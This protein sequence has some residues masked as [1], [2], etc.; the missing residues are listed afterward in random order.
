[1]QSSVKNVYGSILAFLSV[2]VFHFLNVAGV[3]YTYMTTA[4][5]KTVKPTLKKKT[6][7]NCKARR[8]SVDSFNKTVAFLRLYTI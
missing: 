2:T 4:H 5:H 6:L 8:S 1:M 7:K 3:S